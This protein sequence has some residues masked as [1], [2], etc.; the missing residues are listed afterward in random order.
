MNTSPLI[1]TAAVVLL[2]MAA[3]A[4]AGEGC[5]PEQ[6]AK[7]ANMKGQALGPR[8][9]SG[10]E[11]GAMILQHFEKVQPPLSDAQ[12]EQIK[13]L[14]EQTRAKIMAAKTPEERRAIHMDMRKTIVNTILTEE[15][16]ASM[17][18]HGKGPRA[19]GAPRV[20]PPVLPH[21]M[22][23]GEGI[24][25]HFASVTPP[26]SDEQKAHIKQLAAETNAKIMAAT[27]PEE[28]R[29]IH[30]DMRKTIVNTILTEEQRASLPYHGKG[31]RARWRKA[32]MP[33]LPPPPPAEGMQPPPPP[34]PPVE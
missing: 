16:R 17:P 5:C 30:A 32:P 15:Q 13:K 31:P 14:A 9:Q 20:P 11:P 26:L 12:K 21:L 1:C 33:P 8:P 4:F 2:G 27:T 29:A 28:R 34:P 25:Q 7:P 23:P 6:S 3:S 19:Q 22:A 18:Y 24:I 10:M